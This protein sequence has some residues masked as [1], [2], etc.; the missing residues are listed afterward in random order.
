[1]IKVLISKCITMLII[2]SPRFMLLEA[3]S[4]IQSLLF[5]LQINLILD[6]LLEKSVHLFSGSFDG[7]TGLLV[8]NL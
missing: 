6:F 4:C 2:I 5:P 1:M 8:E 7:D 3:R